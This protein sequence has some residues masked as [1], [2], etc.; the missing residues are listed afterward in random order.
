MT[1]HYKV[2]FTGLDMLRRRETSLQRCSPEFSESL[3]SS[4]VPL[5]ALPSLISLKGVD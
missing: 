2:L 3:R 5:L 1:L 4:F